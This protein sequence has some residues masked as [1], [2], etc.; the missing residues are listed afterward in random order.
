[1][2]GISEI[3]VLLIVLM[4]VIFTVLIFRRIFELK[5]E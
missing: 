4:F 1:M 2:I 3:I 5:K